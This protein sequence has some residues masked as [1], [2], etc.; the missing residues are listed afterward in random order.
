MDRVE[1]A[2]LDR[3]AAAGL[4]ARIAATARMILLQL[5]LPLLLLLLLL[6]L[7][8]MIMM[9]M[10]IM[11]TIIMAIM[12]VITTTTRSRA[13]GG[14][15]AAGPGSLAGQAASRMA[16]AAWPVYEFNLLRNKLSTWMWNFMIW[17]FDVIL[18][19]SY[20]HSSRRPSP[21]GWRRRD[22]SR[23]RRGRRK[24]WGCQPAPREAGNPVNYQPQEAQP[25]YTY[26]QPQ[27]GRATPTYRSHVMYNVQF[28]YNIW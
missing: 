16:G 4:A 17:F 12:I 13:E 26:A 25:Q 20:N 14:G 1:T 23:L 9:M 5:Q 21:T 22:R 7:L 11:K 2:G 6:L 3:R 24:P 15:R 8:M 28:Q 10:I 27:A 19:F 18:W